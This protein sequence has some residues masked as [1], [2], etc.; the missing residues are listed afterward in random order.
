MPTLPD[1]GTLLVRIDFTDDDAWGQLQG[2]ATREY[3]PDGFSANVEPVN[4]PQWADVAWDLVKAA[5]PAGDTGPTV[6]FI[7]DSVTFASP[8][9]PVLVVDLLDKCLSVTEFPHIAGRVP[10]RCIPAALWEVENNLNLANMDWEE[11][12]GQVEGGVYR[13]LEL[14]P[15]TAEE[16]AEAERQERERERLAQERAQS[17]AEL[18]YWGGRLPSDRLRATVGNARAAAQLD[19]ALA[20]AIAAASPDT[21]RSI[22]ARAAHRAYEIA[23]IADL[24]WA[25]P[26]LRALAE[27]RDLPPPFNDR[28][29]VFQMLHSDPR[30]PRTT[31]VSLDGGIP[32]LLRAAMAVPA[33]FDATEPDPL[34]AALKALYAAAV[35]W[36]PDDYPGFSAEIRRTYG[37]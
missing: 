31:V 13:G 28:Q 9:H 24:D 26:A 8:A 5:A 23:G 4:D 25:A 20:E 12:A 15:L 19:P 22:A 36:G 37:L 3:G 34:R 7:A 11:F 30:V 29:Q 32:N 14:P 35:T 27:G 33:L 17:A 2:E 21:Q 10:F 18:G 16:K 1:R 6:L